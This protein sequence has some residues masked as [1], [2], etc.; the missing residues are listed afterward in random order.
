VCLQRLDEMLLTESAVIQ[1]LD[2]LVQ[3]V[4]GT[5]VSV[6]RYILL[7]ISLTHTHII[8]SHTFALLYA[9]T[10]ILCFFDVHCQFYLQ[11]CWGIC[12]ATDQNVYAK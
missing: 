2:I 11:A 1:A 10:L 9:Y 4:S 12:L 7:H 6:Y 5:F 8:I 3:N